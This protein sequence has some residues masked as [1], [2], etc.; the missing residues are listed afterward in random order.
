M[1][2]GT[3]RVVVRAF[4]EGIIWFRMQYCTTTLTLFSKMYGKKYT[5]W[6]LN[7]YNVVNNIICISILGSIVLWI[8]L[9]T[10]FYNILLVSLNKRPEIGREY[11]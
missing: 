2:Q 4:C 5:I 8:I 7:S 3:D 6:A 1:C 9:D 11:K 10:I